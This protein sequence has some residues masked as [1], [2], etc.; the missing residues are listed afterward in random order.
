[1]HFWHSVRMGEVQE[2]HK[3]IL[4]Y[5]R[6]H[7]NIVGSTL[8]IVSSLLPTDTASAFKQGSFSSL[9][10]NTLKPRSERVAAMHKVPLVHRLSLS[11]VMAPAW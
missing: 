6:D 1:M 2:T 11:V 5:S 9:K 3:P 4:S 10:L 7:N 8:F